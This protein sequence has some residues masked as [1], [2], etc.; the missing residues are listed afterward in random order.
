[1]FNTELSFEMTPSPQRVL[2]VR[3][4]YEPEEG[5]APDCPGAAESVLIH[6]VWMVTEICP[7]GG[8]WYDPFGQLRPGP[9]RI[10]TEITEHLDRGELRDIASIILEARESLP[11]RETEDA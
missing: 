6:Q 1:M 9:R 11:L 7:K 3:F 4:E 10:R 2:E 5:E 8:W